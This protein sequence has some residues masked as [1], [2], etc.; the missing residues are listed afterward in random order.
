[1]QE[2]LNEGKLPCS[3]SKNLGATGGL[4]RWRSRG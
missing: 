2:D 4:S 1:M 3:A